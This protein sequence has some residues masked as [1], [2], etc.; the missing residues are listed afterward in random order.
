MNTNVC[1]E[2]LVRSGDIPDD[3]KVVST[4]NKVVVVSQGH[5][6]VARIGSLADINQRDDPHDLRYSHTA[7]WLAGDVA[8]VVKPLHNEPLIRSGY[9]ISSYPLLKTGVDLGASGANNIYAM[10]RDFGNALTT[11]TEGMSLRR[12]D[13]A[14][15]VQARLKYMRDSLDHDQRAVEYVAEEID[16]LNSQCPF[17]ELVEH[18]TALIHGDIK[19]D[20]VVATSSGELRIID[21]DAV[22]IGPRLYDLASWRLRSELGDSAPVENTVAIGRQTATWDEES[23]RS[24]IGW[25][26]VSSMS[27]TLRY[28]A[29]EV[30]RD[31]MIQIADSA[32]TLGGLSVT[33]TAICA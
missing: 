3:V 12:L 7:S 1:I 30:S 13:V 22:A 21:L 24:L 28:E 14:Q 16:R 25:K 17:S 31:K 33:P 15:Y 18:D 29:P 2:S 9:V 11:V 20:N 8:P 4:N 19:T 6:L 5:H 27:Y 23:Y 26:A 10:V 32:Y